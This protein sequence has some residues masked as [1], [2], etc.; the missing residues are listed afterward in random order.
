MGEGQ[1]AGEAPALLC[2]PLV[3][4]QVLEVRTGHPVKL[5]ILLSAASLLAP[6]CPV[7][8]RTVDKACL[9][10]FEANSAKTSVSD[11]VRLVLGERSA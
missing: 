5:V 10:A 9:V 4:Q 2:L 1:V 11:K 8:I 3:L 6:G 7:A